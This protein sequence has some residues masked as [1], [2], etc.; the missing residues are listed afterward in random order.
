MFDFFFLED[1]LAHCLCCHIILVI[2]KAGFKF[3]FI[4]RRTGMVFV[5][6]LCI[7]VCVGLLYLYL[8]M[9]TCTFRRGECS[10]I[11]VNECWKFKAA[12]DKPLCI[13]VVCGIKYFRTMTWPKN[14]RWPYIRLCVYLYTSVWIRIM[15]DMRPPHQELESILSRV[16]ATYPKNYFGGTVSPMQKHYRGLTA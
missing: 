14:R 7:Y 8:Y 11:S 5:G 15:D 16:F 1:W 10:Y 4:L 3:F 12:W 9:Y 13:L 2:I 6:M